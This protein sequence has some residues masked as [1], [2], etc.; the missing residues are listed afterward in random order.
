M[1]NLNPLHLKENGISVCSLFYLSI[2]GLC[3]SWNFQTKFTEFRP[4]SC[5][6]CCSLYSKI[7]RSAC[8]NCENNSIIKGM[9][10]HQASF[11]IFLELLPVSNLLYLLSCDI[12][13]ADSELPVV[14]AV[15]S[16]PVGLVG[17]RHQTWHSLL[18]LSPGVDHCTLGWFNKSVV[19]FSN[20]LEDVY[21]LILT[22]GKAL[23][24]ICRLNL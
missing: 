23:F 10:L 17:L 15:C 22:D 3:C 8:N 9:E 2:M 1:S 6:A 7:A 21:A 18:L 19:P 4:V 12:S 20:T 16:P 5:K 13:N 11:P 14:F 24:Q